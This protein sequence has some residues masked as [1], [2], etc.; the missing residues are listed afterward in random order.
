MEAKIIFLKISQ[1]NI[2]AKPHVVAMFLIVML[3]DSW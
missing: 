1:D 3:T 2:N